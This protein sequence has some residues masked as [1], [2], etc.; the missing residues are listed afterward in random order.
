MRAQP[1]IAPRCDIATFNPNPKPA[2]L[3]RMIAS[4][5]ATSPTPM[6]AVMNAAR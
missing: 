4:A 1:E 3:P 5:A 6:N 2:S